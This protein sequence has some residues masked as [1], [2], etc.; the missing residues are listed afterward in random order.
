MCL[1]PQAYY[2]KILQAAL[3][4]IQSHAVLC[5]VA[6][7]K[8]MVIN[9]KKVSTYTQ[10]KFMYIPL[11]NFVN[12]FIWMYNLCFVL[13]KPWFVLFKAVLIMAACSI[14]VLIAVNIIY[15]IFPFLKIIIFCAE[16]YLWPLSCSY[17][18]IR[19]QESL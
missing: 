3:V 5:L 14:A 7:R 13:K 6:Q 18:L 10:R 1:H 11:V 9:M 15:A 8:G 2:N 4:A 16:L 12:L 19:Y 17:G